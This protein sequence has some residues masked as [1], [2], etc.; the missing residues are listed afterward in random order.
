MGSAP[1]CTQAESTEKPGMTPRAEGL[2]T[3]KKRLVTPPSTE[4][5]GAFTS[6]HPAGEAAQSAG[7]R[8]SAATLLVSVAVMAFAE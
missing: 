4:K 7:G 8:S 5:A 2:S 3:G 6:A 1:G